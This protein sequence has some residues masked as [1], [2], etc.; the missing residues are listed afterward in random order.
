MTATPHSSSDELDEIL[1]GLSN[2]ILTDRLYDSAYTS[3]ID[4]YFAEAK[5]KLQALISQEA[6]KARI[7]EWAKLVWSEDVTDELKDSLNP[8]Y[9]ARYDE[10]QA[11]LTKGG[12]TDGDSTYRSESAEH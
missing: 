10:L 1:D 8:Y 5:A 6:A 12:D 2:Q 11:A 3:E 4:E 9:R 7:D